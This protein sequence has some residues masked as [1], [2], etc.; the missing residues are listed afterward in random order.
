[1]TSDVTVS[2]YDVIKVP[3]TYTMPYNIAGP[4]MGWHP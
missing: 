2:A 1:L 3:K 4:I